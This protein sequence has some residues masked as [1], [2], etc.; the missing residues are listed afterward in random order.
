MSNPLLDTALSQ[1]HPVLYR[2]VCLLV[3][4]LGICFASPML[5][6]GEEATESH[7]LPL[8]VKARHGDTPATLAERYLNDA[9]KAWMI[10]EYN[11]LLSFS[12][13][14]AVLV[15]TA[16]FRL[17]GLS[18]SGYQSVPVLAYTTVSTDSKQNG[19]IT[20]FIFE[21]Q[22]SWLDN[23][24]YKAISPAQLL[25][26]MNFSGQLPKQATLITADTESALFFDHMIPVL[27]SFGFTATLFVAVDQVGK[28]GN[29]TWDQLRL[30][31]ETGFTIG[32]RGASGRALV[33]RQGSKFLEDDFSRIESELQAAKQAV[34][35]HIG[36]T[37]TVL[38]YPVGSAN[39]LVA[40][41]AAKLGFSL[42]FDQS[43]G[44]N[45]FFGD[46][47][48]VHRI[49]IDKPIRPGEFTR[50]LTTLITADLD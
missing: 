39:D 46:R 5:L 43:A 35:Q 42:A 26:F 12:E 1:R 30:L 3:I 25:D 27:R 22:M 6:A 20:P 8:L 15:P 19:K 14:Q 37:C 21:E 40:A 24:G 17:G 36:S 47:F 44:E 7:T 16:P 13:G 45:P 9:A 32:C 41:M 28:P 48:G 23:S 2:L 50:M 29:M 11:G 18:P 49:V 38:A 33:P 31:D 34:E 10:V 4:L